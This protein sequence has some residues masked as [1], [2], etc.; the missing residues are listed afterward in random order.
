M[1]EEPKENFGDSGRKEKKKVV[2]VYESLWSFF[3]FSKKV[4]G[5]PWLV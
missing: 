3:F 2:C 4:V 5:L 1:W